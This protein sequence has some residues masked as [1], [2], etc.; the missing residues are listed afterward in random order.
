[1]SL[2]QLAGQ[3]R[4][5]TAHSYVLTTLRDA[6]LKGALPAGSRLIQA[7]LA[8]QLDVSITPVREALRDLAGEGLVVL[9]AHKG[10][11]VR[12]LDL[13]EVREI[14]QLRIVLEPLMVR[15]VINTITTEQLDRAEALHTKIDTTEDLA[16]WSELNRQ[17]HSIFAEN[18]RDS[19]LAQI[20]TGLRDSAST[21]V[22]LSL[23]VDP[24]RI[25][26][27]NAEHEQLIALY[28]ARDL[29][30]AVKLTVQ[31]LRSTLATIEDAHQKGAL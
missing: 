13:D 11:R 20:L 31:H 22:S 1:M 18:D 2:T 15:R 17:F 28:R 6:I 23:G 30:G 12:S 7:D 16:L 5:L 27:S 4:N 29:Q 3:S 14:Y 24:E 8:A 19:R 26:V 21:Y 25:I 9:D 10:S